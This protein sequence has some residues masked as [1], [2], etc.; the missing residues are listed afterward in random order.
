M[1]ANRAGERKNAL[2]GPRKS[3]I[4]LD[5]DKEIQAFPL[6]G[7]GRAWLDLAQFGPIWIPLGFSLDTLHI[8]ATGLILSSPPAGLR[9]AAHESSSRRRLELSCKAPAAEGNGPRRML[10]EMA[11]CG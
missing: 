9:P 6:V 10:L 4:R 11:P 5:S 1:P 2:G 7:F 8:G 3:L